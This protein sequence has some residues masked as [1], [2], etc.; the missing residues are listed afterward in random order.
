MSVGPSEHGHRES[1]SASN[2]ATA[3]AKIKMAGFSHAGQSCI[4]TQRILVHRSIADDF[5]AALVAHV[6]ALVVG[7]PMDEATDVS[8]LISTA[9]RDRVELWIKEADAAGATI[10]TGGRRS[11]DGVLMPTVITGATPGM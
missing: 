1:G 5:T 3:A 4:S 8:A 9:E 10:A 7:D 2:W 6:E 11:S